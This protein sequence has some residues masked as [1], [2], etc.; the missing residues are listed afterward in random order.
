LTKS[1]DLANVQEWKKAAELAAQGR[2]ALP[3]IYQL[4]MDQGRSGDINFN[5]ALTENDRKL[6]PW[7]K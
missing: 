3:D 1:L 6:Q 4:K 5:V 2:G 7:L